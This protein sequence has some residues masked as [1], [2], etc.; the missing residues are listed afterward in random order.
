MK[1]IQ[2]LFQ[3]PH[4]PTQCLYYCDGRGK[5]FGII[6]SYSYIYAR[7]V[8]VT[9]NCFGLTSTAYTL[10]KSTDRRCVIIEKI[11]ILMDVRNANFIIG[12]VH[13]LVDIPDGHIDIIPDFAHCFRSGATLRVCAYFQRMA[14]QIVLLLNSKP[15][16]ITRINGEHPTNNPT[17]NGA[18]KANPSVGCNRKNQRSVRQPQSGAERNAYGNKNS[19]LPRVNP[20]H[21][22]T[23]PA[24]PSIVERVVA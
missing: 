15:S 24:H 2:Q 10:C 12:V 9:H 8:Y 3:Y 17:E 23:L 14:C 20:P 13:D 22:L 11:K 18:R 7:T 5:I 19:R 16:Q 1:L 21:S 4:L 6:R